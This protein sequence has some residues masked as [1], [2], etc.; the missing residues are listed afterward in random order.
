MFSPSQS[1]SRSFVLPYNVATL[2]SW[3]RKPATLSRLVSLWEKGE[4]PLLNGKDV[5]EGA[6][7][8]SLSSSFMESKSKEYRISKLVENQVI[9]LEGEGVVKKWNLTLEKR[10]DSETGVTLEVVYSLLSGEAKIQTALTRCQQ[11]IEQDTRVLN[12]YPSKSL[13]L[14]VSGTTGMLGRPLVVFLRSSGHDVVR[15]VRS[16][17]AV[18][19]DAI[20]WDPTKDEYDT[21]DFEGFDAVIH[22]AGRNVASHLWSQEEKKRIFQSRCRDTW[23]LSTLLSRLQMP[24][25]VFLTASAVGFYGN[26]GT[27]RLSEES[28]KGEGFLSDLV[29]NWEKASQ[30]L[31]QRGT[32]I[33]SMRFG[34]ILSLEGGLLQKM[35][36][37]FR[38]GLGGTLG[39]GKQMM[40][41]VCVDDAIYAI[42]HTLHTQVLNGPINVVA[43]ETV[44]NAQFVSKLATHLHRLAWVRL[45]A[46]VLK[47]IFG[48]M[49]EELLLT[50]AVAEPKKLLK[51]GFCFAYPTLD[52]ALEHFF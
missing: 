18:R 14:L 2:F 28:S 9:C 45:P 37:V 38:L 15:L 7:F 4:A 8:F 49:A 33:G 12:S 31:L 52:A 26:R 10:S 24:P 39:N 5:E 40:S 34:A 29:A 50:S 47:L 20:F 46:C 21:S 1:V 51:S 16:R 43:P 19:E 41:W 11:T 25:K 35:V 17:R 36:P 32:K 27:E 6:R 3:L 23:L 30:P 42:Y 44:S 22:L 13:R 48:Q